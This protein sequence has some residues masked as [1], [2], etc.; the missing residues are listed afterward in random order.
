M[1]S[2]A[3]TSAG[4]VDE[5]GRQP[6]VLQGVQHARGVAGAVV[7]H[8]DHARP[9]VANAP[10]RSAP[11]G[12]RCSTVRVRVRPRSY[13]QPGLNPGLGCSDD[14]L[15]RPHRRARVS[16]AAAALLTLLLALAGCIPPPPPPPP[17]PTTAPPAPGSAGVPVMGQS[18][19]TAAQL[20]AFYQT[21]DPGTLPYR[22][23]G[24][25]LQQLADMFVTEGNRY[26]VR[27]DIAFAQS[28][29]ETAWFNYPDYGLV[30]PSDN[31]FAGHRSMLFVW[32]RL[33][34]H[35]RAQRRA[36]PAA[37]A[38]QLRRRDSRAATIPDPP[39]PELWGSTPATANYNFDH[40]FAKGRAPLW[41]EHGQRQLGHLA[42]LRDRRAPRLQP[43]ADLQRC[44]VRR[45][46]RTPGAPT[47]GNGAAVHDGK[48]LL[49]NPGTS[50]GK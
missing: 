39:V 30:R 44:A 6:Q 28:I 4:V 14:S 36:R 46:V 5:P 16:L 33:R 32:H 22:A 15:M 1:R 45:V 9:K 19:L 23:T 24:A 17:P 47:H 11:F 21:T 7:D 37:A 12:R 20:V 49:R 31:N 29:V 3:A 2:A 8:V 42:R 26:N 35:E 50:L 25:T 18:Q 41:N 27:G 43:D 48:L 10:G 34:V 40:Y 38:P 13:D